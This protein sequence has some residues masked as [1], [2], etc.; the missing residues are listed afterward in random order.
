VVDHQVTCLEWEGGL[1][2]SFT[3]H[4]HSHDNVR[5]LRYSGTRATLR[6]HEGAQEI[7]IH[8]YLTGRVDRIHPG[9]SVGGHGGGDTGLMNAFIQ[10][11]RDPSSAAALTSGR[12]S[13]ES[14]LLA[15][16][17]ERARKEGRVVDMEA[18]RQEIEAAVAEE[19]PPRR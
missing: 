15:F 10:A 8:D 13:L 1:T 14:H 7:T 3:M 18:Y 6:G 11:M 2:V 4:G 19:S 5:T 17:A 12:N 9:H 16:A